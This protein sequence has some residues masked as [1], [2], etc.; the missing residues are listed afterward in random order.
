MQALGTGTSGAFGIV[1]PASVGAL[2]EG[3]VSPAGA[4]VGTELSGTDDS[5]AQVAVG[6]VSVAASVRI[7]VASSRRTWRGYRS[8]P[9]AWRQRGRRRG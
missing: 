4:L 1:V 8:D 9:S 7:A 6:T 5:C 2:P 3:A